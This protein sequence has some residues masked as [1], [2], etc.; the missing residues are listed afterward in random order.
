[1]CPIAVFGKSLMSLNLT[2]N[3]DDFI[4]Q[5]VDSFARAFSYLVKQF[6]SLDGTFQCKVVKRGFAPLGGGQV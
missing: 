1:M 2:G 5:S 6:G 4:D 3:T